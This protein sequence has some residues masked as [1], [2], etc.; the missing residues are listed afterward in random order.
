[1]DF[2]VLN[3]KTFNVVQKRED[4]KSKILVNCVKNSYI[5]NNFKILNIRIITK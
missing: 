3:L 1:M 4:L 2:K 5:Y